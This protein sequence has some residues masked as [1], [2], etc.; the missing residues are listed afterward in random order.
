MEQLEFIIG[1]KKSGDPI[2][3]SALDHKILLYINIV[4]LRIF[5]P[6]HLKFE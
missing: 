3:F 1:P 6:F 5:I 4:I 2:S